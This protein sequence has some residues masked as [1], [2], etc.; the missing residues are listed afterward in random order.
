MTSSYLLVLALELI[1]EVLDQPVIEVLTTKVSVTS[2]SLDLEDA[3]LDGEERHIEGTTAKIEDQDVAL[4]LVLLVEAVGNGGSGGL[5]DDTEN[6]EAGNETGVLG[7]L[8]LRVV[9]V[10]G[11]GDNGVGDGVADVGLGRLPHLGED[12]GRDLLGGELLGLALELD[13]GLGLAGLVDDLEGE[14]LHVG[15]D[16]GVGE[17]AADETLGVEDGVPGVHGDLVLGGISDET[18]SVGEGDCRFMLVNCSCCLAAVRVGWDIS[19]GSV[20]EER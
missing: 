2:G 19:C 12:H 7:G 14:V 15:L 5:V 4:A 13:L 17:L 6:V 18:L 16:L 11:D 1:K 20:C 8:A 9:E 10:G 3:L